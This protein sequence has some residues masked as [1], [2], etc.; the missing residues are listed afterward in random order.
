MGEG[1]GETMGTTEVVRE[2]G[3]SRPTLYTLINE[4]VL[5]PLPYNTL[6]K[7]PAALRFLREDVERVKREGRKSRPPE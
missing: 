1:D 5:K 7:R 4:G 3:I 6:L 2:L